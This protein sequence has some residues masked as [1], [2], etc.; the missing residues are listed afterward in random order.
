MIV[1]CAAQTITQ[2][3]IMAT[4]TIKYNPRS[5]AANIL[6]NLIRVTDD[7]QIVDMEPHIPNAATIAAM[8]EARR[9]GLKTYNSVDELFKDLLN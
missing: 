5:K 9:G 4:I 7:L 3:T 6:L 1:P 2:V 8:Q